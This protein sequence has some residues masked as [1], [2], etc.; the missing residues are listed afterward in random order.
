MKYVS[1]ILLLCFGGAAGSQT[2]APDSNLVKTLF[3]AGLRDKLRENYP[4]AQINF[5]KILET[6]PT[7]DAV[8]FE[9]ATLAFRQNKL[10]EAESA[11]KTAIS[12]DKNN[13]WYHKMLAEVYKRTNNMSSLILTY[14][15]LIRLEPENEDYYFDRANAWFISGKT[16]EALKNYT[17]VEHQFGNSPALNEARERIQMTDR[18][19]PATK[20]IDRL[21]AAN[22]SD[23]KNYLYLSGVL[24]EKNKKAEA[25]AL[26]QKAKLALPDSYQLDVS[27]ADIYR[28]QKDNKQSIR[29]LSLAFRNTLM[30]VEDKVKI[31]T[32]ALSILSNSDAHEAYTGL[33]RDLAEMHP[34]YAKARMI[35]GDI[36]FI[37]GQLPE[38][39]KQY[40]AVL[41]TTKQLYAAWEQL[42]NTEVNLGEY[43]EAMALGEEALTLYPNQGILYY[44]LAF[45]Q[46]R[47][48][49]N[50]AT[51]SNIKNA[52][53][54]D[55]DN[56]PLKALIYSLQGEIL[57]DQN[58]LTQANDAFEKSIATDPT[59]FL[60]LN[61]YAFYLALRGQDL[62]KA[63]SLIEKAAVGD[64]QNT[65]IADT[66]AFVLFKQ[67]KYALAKNWIEKAIQNNATP[68]PVYLEHYGDI[69]FA[70]GDKERALLEWKKS[71]A[72][73]N[74]SPKLSQKINEQKYIK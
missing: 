12:I 43:K 9:V 18:P 15:E 64:P 27:M 26:L 50:E 71:K 59:N 30:P 6:E 48:G 55:E 67:G 62:T 46:H 40:Q 47:A 68:N 21:V 58:K 25:L 8:W 13:K 41:A 65:S 2:V 51:P 22:P 49:L 31:L 66:Y 54:L 38:A 1:I 36:L 69:L 14:N 11:L 24:M 61:N 72:A 10:I 33:A 17:I 39:K 20:D 37:Q 73:G 16:S 70:L 3:F 44:Y 52:L 56:K 35:Y 57:L 53:L 60:L 34:D 29:S 19:A 74:D 28:M 7:N 4:S 45:A 32:S 42:L 63:A 5:N 23:V